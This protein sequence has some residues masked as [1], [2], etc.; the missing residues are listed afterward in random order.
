M[1]CF[2]DLSSA[3]KI[4]QQ[5]QEGF[6]RMVEGHFASRTDRKLKLE[7]LWLWSSFVF[8]VGTTDLDITKK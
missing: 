5:G 8:D 7:N 4:A 6:Y 3:V 2:V 1:I